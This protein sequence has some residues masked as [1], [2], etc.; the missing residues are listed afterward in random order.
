MERTAGQQQPLER[1]YNSMREMLDHPETYPVRWIREELGVPALRRMRD[2]RE[3]DL[4]VEQD[5]TP[6]IAR[7]YDDGGR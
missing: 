1:V 5:L 6:D 3:A 2:I 7:W 4:R